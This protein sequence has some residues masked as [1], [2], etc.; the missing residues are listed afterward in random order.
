MSEPQFKVIVLLLKT[1]ADSP[2]AQISGAGL[3]IHQT[4]AFARL[5]CQRGQAFTNTAR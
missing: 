5:P 3:R 1:M 4:A 2:K